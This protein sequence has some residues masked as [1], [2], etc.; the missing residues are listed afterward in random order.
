MTTTLSIRVSVVH[1]KS[2]EHNSAVYDESLETVLLANSKAI[3]LINGVSAGIR[4][5]EF[6]GEHSRLVRYEPGSSCSEAR[7]NSRQKT[8]TR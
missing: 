5:K 2:C 3:C 4:H 1:W 6:H 7:P 8:E